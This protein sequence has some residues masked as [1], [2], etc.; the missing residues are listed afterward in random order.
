MTTWLATYR[1]DWLRSDAVG[2]LT[3]AAVVIPKA[4]ACAVIAGLPVEAGLYTALAATL[5]YP[6][7]GS[8]R[9]LSVSSTSAIAML[10]AAAI[11]DT[12]APPGTEPVTIAATMALLVGVF[13]LAARLIGLGFLA[14]FI[15]KPVLVGFAAGVGLAI[16]IG[17]A[18]ALL[19]LHLESHGTV[20]ILLELPRA[21]TATHGLTLLVSAV[22]IGLLLGLHRYL[23][24]APAPLIWVGL[25][26]LASAALNLREQGVALVGSVPPGLPAVALPDLALIPQLW[27]AALGIALMSFTESVA[28]ARTFRRAQDARVDADQELLAIG[29]AN[30]AVAMVGG[31][32][33]GGGTS[34]T[35]V[36]DQAGV[37]SQMAQ[38]VAAAATLVTLLLFSGLIGLLPQ[39]ALAALVVVVSIGM[40]KPMDF[41]AIRQIRRME[42]LWALATLVGVVLI[43]TLEG[44]GIAVVISMLTLIYQANHPPVYEVTYSRDKEVFRRAGENALDET[45]PGLL[46][47]R[48]E[49]RLNFANAANAQDKMQALVAQSNP[50][51]IVLECSAI[52][53]IEYTALAMLTEAEIQLRA[54]GVRLWLA[55][56]NPDLFK[57]IMRSPLGAALGQERMHF[58]LRIALAAFERDAG[59]LPAATSKGEIP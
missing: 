19:G 51:V 18:K 59:A 43:G 26:I 22:G 27:P 30:V 35:A 29:A 12:S 39:A 50:R 52:P 33:A 1:R 55:A 38:W 28:A 58:N 40:I 37:R 13:L 14:N 15:S 54:R 17:Q 46:M 44:I 42:W 9:A 16:I 2:G 23:P 34:Q 47:L 31:L 53:D 5:I 45:I 56:I 11:A 21:I 8:S 7:L 24:R 49:G 48:A 6:L 25:A 41:R 57:T 20:G 10:M 4:M 3:T 36:A 32:P